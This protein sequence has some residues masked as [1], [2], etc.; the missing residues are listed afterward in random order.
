MW[1][2]PWDRKPAKPAIRQQ[3]DPGEKPPLPPAETHEEQV[4][5]EAIEES[6]PAS[7]PPAHTLH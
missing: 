7:D 5:D 2:L 4:I 3:L 1:H 6:F